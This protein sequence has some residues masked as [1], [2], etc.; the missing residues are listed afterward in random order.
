[1]KN[2]IMDKGKQ[3]DKYL[4]NL[5]KKS[6]N[7]ITSIMKCSTNKREIILLASITNS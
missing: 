7:N 1:M 5:N 3:E 4:W 2:H 6:K